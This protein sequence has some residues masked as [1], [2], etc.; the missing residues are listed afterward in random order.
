MFRTTARRRL[1]LVVSATLLAA[2]LC[3]TPLLAQTAP[4]VTSE[5]GGY[6]LPPEALRAIVDAPRPPRLLLSPQR[7]L[8]AF[9]Q[10]PALPS[11]AEV[12]QP[13]L[14]LGGIRI[15]PRTWSASR[16]SYVTDVWLKP[17]DGD[18]EQRI[19]GLPEPL[20]LASLLWSPDQRHIAFSQVDVRAGEVQL[21]VVDVATR[22]ARRLLAQPLNAVI[23]NGFEWAP[24]SQGLLVRLRAEGQAALP[25]DDG[26]PA[27]PN[28][29]ETG[30][31]GTV[32]QLRTYQDLLRSEQ[33]ARV[34][35]HYMT[36]QL[37]RVA[38]DGTVVPVGTPGL[39][40]SATLS[41]DGRHILRQQIDRPFSYQVP[42]SRFPRRIEVIGLDG[43]L[44][45]TV[46]TLPLVEGLPVGNDAVPTGVRSVSWRSDAPATLAWVE[47]QDGGDPAR[48]VA[49][50]DIVYT[51]AAPFR[52]KPDVLAELSMRYA[53]TQWGSG[54]LA[55][56]TEYWWKTRQIREWRLQPD[57]SA[58]PV[59][60]RDGSY[61]D[62]YADPGMAV[63]M[64]DATGTSR[65]L[66]AADGNS[67]YRIGDGAS[68]EGDRPFLDR[69]NLADGSTTRLFHSQAPY[70]ESPSAVLDAEAT[71]LLTSRETQTEPAN[72]YVRRLDTLDADPVALT[73]FEHPTPQLRDVQ[74][75]L[76]RFKRK[77]GV[78]LSGTLYLP[79]GYD[80]RRDGPLP[81][82]MW[83]YPGEFKSADAASQVTDSPHRFNA[84]GYWG[85]QAYL[86]MGYAVFADVSMP[87]IGEG[88]AEPNDT[89]IEQLVAS[90]EAAID[91]AVRRGVADR[92]R[93][94]IGGHS[95]GAFMTGN[96]LA[97]S[98]L[99]AAGIARSGAYNRTL[100]P[101]GFQAEERNYWQAE[102]TYLKMSPFNYAQNIKDPILLIHGEEDNNSG[103]F[104]M[105]SE[106]MFA[107]IKG[108]GGNARLVMLPKESHGYRA[109]ESILHM[110]YETNAWLETYVKN[111]AAED[112]AR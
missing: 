106:R 5:A 29:Q 27:G 41:P 109:R 7:D 89:Y 70:Y 6:R 111:R 55:L 31:G 15:N 93:V 37:A 68:E 47:A 30:A 3:S 28:V 62:R 24:D 4:A 36:S 21:W 40:T 57:G 66:I 79:A 49:V 63:M 14:K 13:E 94:A 19:A 71:R 23:G 34:F 42:Y 52:G 48:E 72:I 98:R 92:R 88:T 95:Y 22:Q 80:A 12:S 97:H 65:L 60:V 77:D 112:A 16:A 53:G 35:A 76:V 64:P 2:G 75:E 58:A 43:K 33:D 1:S 73:A 20:S 108:L 54:E 32:Q 45:H 50:R 105:Q 61:E 18:A 102:D 17:V 74:K 81:M 90:A 38:L 25:Q 46:A 103:T 9:L 11:I 91:E 85:P 69:Q 51:Q 110:L 86:A 10:T 99:F 107:A 67:I 8:A 78:D 100:T 84:I 44:Q 101:F 39:T 104:P 59:K 56:L 83:A 96:L 82:L 26:V 87:I